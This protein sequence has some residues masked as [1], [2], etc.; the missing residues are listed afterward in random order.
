MKKHFILKNNNIFYK[1][2]GE[3]QEVKVITFDS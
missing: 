1:Y 2:M 3:K